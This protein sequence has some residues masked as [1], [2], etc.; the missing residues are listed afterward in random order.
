VRCTHD[1]PFL[2]MGAWS[3]Y[4]SCP[5][6]ELSLAQRLVASLRIVSYG[7]ARSSDVMGASVARSRTVVAGGHST[8]GQGSSKCEGRVPGQDGTST[9]CL[10][11][12]IASESEPGQGNPT[13]EMTAC[14]PRGGR[15]ASCAESALG[16]G[17]GTKSAGNGTTAEGNQQGHTSSRTCE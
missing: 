3:T 8:R 14:G 15:A 16:G 1:W 13:S 7:S 9:N 10:I 2:N 11:S 12:A 6:I 4:T 5:D 17:G